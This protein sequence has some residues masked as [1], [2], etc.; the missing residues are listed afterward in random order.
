MTDPTFDRDFTAWLQERAQPHAPSGLAADIVE[1]TARTRPRS[2]WRIPGRWLSMP[3]TIR[4]A[5]VPRG[6]LLLL[7]LWLILALTVA[8]AAIGGRITFARA[9]LVPAPVTGPAAN[10]LIAFERDGDIYVIEPD[11]SSA[12]PLVDAPGV[13]AVP[14]WS[15]DGTRIAFWSAPSADGPWDITVANADGSGAVTIANGLIRMADSFGPD[16]SPDGSTLLFNA[17]TVPRG[18]APCIDTTTLGEFCSSRV[19]TAATDGSTGAVPIGDPELDAR[20]P[21]WSPD[22][23][24][25][26]FGGGDARTSTIRLYLMAADGI[27]VRPVSTSRGS[28]WSFIRQGWS[29]D[30]TGIVSQVGLSDWDI[31]LVEADGS[32]ETML[33]DTPTDEVG[34]DFAVD[35]SIG[36]YGEGEDPCCLQVLDAE[37]GRLALPG[38]W[39]V[40]S[41]DASLVVS[42]SAPSGDSLVVVDRAGATLATIPDA[43]IPSWQR[44]APPA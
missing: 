38:G 2:A 34:P 36:W 26:A 13:Q 21:A 33:T 22:G 31:V 18:E 16:W 11:G 10:G 8:G 5:L 28:G 14:V 17:R 6:L 1:R 41:P 39:P 9:A 40:W 19:F 12:R 3:T 20:S 24:T 35:G 7:A 15:R 32:G 43:A 42:A 23:T 37:G 30:G 29:P 44:L 25:I 27:D 4:L